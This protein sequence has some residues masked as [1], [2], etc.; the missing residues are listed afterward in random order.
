[1]AES[2]YRGVGEADRIE[3]KN[4]QQGEL[5]RE[6]KMHKWVVYEIETGPQSGMKSVCT[7]ED[8]KVVQARNSVVCRP[9]R[10]GIESETEAEK[11]ARGSSGDLKSKAKPMNLR[12]V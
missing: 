3:G 12:F 4:P 11:L 5:M 9:I 7:A 6:S 8:W 10:E 2:I 1:M